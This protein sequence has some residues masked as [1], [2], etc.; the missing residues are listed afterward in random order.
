M[1]VLEAKD[2]LVQ[3]AAEQ[4]AL[5]NVPLSDL[6]KRMMY[7]TETGECPEDPFA[8]NDAFEAEY[9]NDKYETKIRKLLV[10]AHE[11]L[12]TEGSP[13]LAQW[14]ESLRALDQ[15]DDYI[16]ILC[17]RSPLARLK[18]AE[19]LRSVLRLL[20]RLALLISVGYVILI[21]LGFVLRVTGISTAF[22]AGAM[23]L[24]TLL[25]LAIRPKLAN[26]LATRPI[27]WV[28]T[29]LLKKGGSSEDRSI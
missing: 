17:G 29:F 18:S 6:E 19:G 26:D 24:I 20:F 21:M 14:E 25:V 7:F 3:Q 5:E 13:A 4:A 11:R 1:R 2:F 12:K 22:F 16:L 9:E 15:T 27:V 8:L 23:F 28:A 10:N